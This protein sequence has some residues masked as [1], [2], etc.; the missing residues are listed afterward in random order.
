MTCAEA[1]ALIPGLLAGDLTPKERAA[2]DA[3]LEACA[4]CKDEVT[5]LLEVT[6]GLDQMPM[7]QPSPAFRERFYRRLNEAKANAAHRPGQGWEIFGKAATILLL[8]GGSFL[9]GF[10]YRGGFARTPSSGDPELALMRQ[11]GEDMRMAGVMLASQGDP[12]DPAP[13]MPL[14]NLLDHDPSESIRLAAVDALY[15]YGNQPRVRERLAAS[16]AH[17]T[18]PR[19]QMALV[20]LLASL[21]ER[22]AVQALR[23]LLANPRTNPEVAR[24][25]EAR[26]RGNPL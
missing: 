25:V 22:R 21:R 15:L 14:L 6:A 23:K 8:V 10:L 3:H 17:Q 24:Q 11:G 16:L 2:L 5:A 18:S 26:L 19:V 13:A 12:D 9:G 4:P 1:D 7:E 20:D